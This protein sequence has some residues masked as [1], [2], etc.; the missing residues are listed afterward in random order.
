MEKEPWAVGKRLINLDEEGKEL[1]VC[2]V[3]ELLQKAGRDSREKGTI[4]WFPAGT[5]AFQRDTC[6]CYGFTLI[7]FSSQ[8]F[9]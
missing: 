5:G 1:R 3:H 6:H 2:K 4:R 7:S 9:I 8:M